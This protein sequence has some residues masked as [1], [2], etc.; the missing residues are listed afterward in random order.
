MAKILKYATVAMAM[1]VTV[2][3]ILLMWACA[4]SSHIP[5]HHSGW[6]GIAGMAFPIFAVANA[7]ALVVW[8]VAKPKYAIVP[9]LGFLVCIS[10]VRAYCPVNIPRKTPADAIKVMSYNVKNF[11]WSADKSREGTQQ[12]LS[13]VINSKADIVCLQE[14][15][16]WSDD[17]DSVRN[18]LAAAYKYMDVCGEDSAPS[19]MR[20]FSRFRII[21]SEQ[22]PFPDSFNSAV[23]YQLLLDGGDTVIVLNNHLQSDNLSESEIRSYSGIVGG[24]SSLSQRH[25]KTELLSLFGKLA[26]ASQ[27]RASQTDSI[28]KFIQT[29]AN[30]PM[31]VCGDFN[32]TPISYARRKIASQLTDAYVETG[33]GPGF[34]FSNN[35]MFVRIDQMMCSR[36]WKPY[37]AKVQSGAKGS[38][39]YP[40]TAFFR[41]KDK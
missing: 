39:H 9:L 28:V 23:A 24:D 17:W 3:I 1:A 40:I 30:T 37:N 34:S 33:F 15:D 16:Y 12:I 31:L 27:A 18:R 32:D 29:H 14:G 26:S 8:L 36:H 13:T 20:C 11:G 35:H 38:D 41:L 10:D 6:I 2:A 7:V 25:S 21:K 5:P 19:T 22:I 4:L